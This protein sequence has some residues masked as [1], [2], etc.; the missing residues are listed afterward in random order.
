MATARVHHNTALTVADEYGKGA[1][2]LRQA[3][4]GH[5]EPLS[6]AG[7]VTSNHHVLYC[8]V[9]VVIRYLRVMSVDLPNA[10]AD[11]TIYRNRAGTITNLMAAAVAVDTMTTEV[12]V[13]Q[14]LDVAVNALRKD[15]TVYGIMVRSA[16]STASGDWGIYFGWMPD[17]VSEDA[18]Y[19]TY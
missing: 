7:V 8:E 13:E 15:D 18:D 2:V 5:W 1:E 10:D 12:I 3:V 14:A 19:L 11:L 9:D 17:A 6:A 4:S 16:G